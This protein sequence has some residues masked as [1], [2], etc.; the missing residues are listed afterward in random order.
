MTEGKMNKSAIA[1]PIRHDVSL[2]S[3]DDLYLFNEGRNYRAYNQLGAHHRVVDGEPGTSFSVWAPNARRV[4]LTGSF[5]SWNRDSHELQPRGSSG[6][7]E[8]FI[9]GVAKGALYKYHIL[10]CNHGHTAEK[11]DPFGVYHEKPPR[12]ASVVWELDYA[13]GDAQWMKSRGSRQSLH[14]PISIYEIHLGC[15]CPKSTTARSPIERSLPS[16]PTTS[17]A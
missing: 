16:S 6:I 10:S 13:W 9:P 7:W 17:S 12:T 14:S 1:A 11:A 15:G 5:N 8:G 4:T 3:A 2:L